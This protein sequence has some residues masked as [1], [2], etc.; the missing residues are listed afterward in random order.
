MRCTVPL[1]FAS[2][3][4]CIIGKGETDGIAQTKIVRERRE[5]SG[6]K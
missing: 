1:V 2:H 5:A 4:H 3:A 6:K